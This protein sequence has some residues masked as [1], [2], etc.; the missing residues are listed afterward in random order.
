[1]HSFPP[2]RWLNIVILFVLAFAPLTTAVSAQ[3]GVSQNDAGA[4]NNDASASYND[5]GADFTAGYLLA[6]LQDGITVEQAGLQ[7]M[8]VLSA[9]AL[10]AGQNLPSGLADIYL[11][12]LAPEVEVLTAAGVLGAQPGVMWAEPDYLAHPAAT[13]PNDPEFANQWGLEQVDAPEAWDVE[14]GNANVVIAVVDSGLDLTHPDLASKLWVNPGEIAGN[15]IDDDNNG[16]IDDVNGWNFYAED[17]NIAD[18]NGH[19]TQVAGVAAAVTDNAEGIAGMC[20]GCTIMPIKAMQASGVANYSDIAQGVLYAA[21]KGAEVINLSLGGYSYSSALHE[22][23]QAAVNDY[24]VVVVGGAGNDGVDTPFYPAAYPEVLAVA[25]TDQSDVRA[26]FSDYGT[27]VDV[28]APAVDITTTF[29]GGDYGAVSGTSYAAPLVS[30]LVGLIRSQQ[31]TW[32]QALVTAQIIHTTNDIDP[33]NPG[34]E[35][36]LGS[37][38]I[39]AHAAVTTT[40]SPLLSLEGVAVN[41]DPLGRPTPGESA[42][43]EITLQNDW[44]D[45]EDLTGE[46]STSDPYVTVITD[47]ASYGDILAGGSATGSPAYGFDVTLGAGYSHPIALTLDLSANGGGYSASLDLVVT[48]RSAEEQVWGTI[49]D[50]TTWTNDKTYI[51]MG[52]IGVAP[53]VTLTI[54]AGTDVLFNGNYSLNVGG[55]LVAD[56]MEEQPIRF[57][58]NTGNDWGR[59]YFDDTSIDA[60]A[61]I[62]GTYQSG[63]ILRWV[64]IEGAAQGIGCNNATPYLSHVTTD[65]GGVSCTTGGTSLWLT[66]SDL[67][68][69]VNVMSGSDHLNWS[70]RADLLTARTGLGVVAASNGKIY[71]IG[72]G[73]Y[74]SIVEAYDPQTDTW[75]TQA[76][77]PTARSLLGVA[78]A[79]NGMIYAIGGYNLSKGEL[80]TVE[81]YNPQTDTWTTKASMPTARYGLGVATTSNGKIYAIG[82]Y[83]QDGQILN[84]VEEYDPQADTWVIRANMPTSRGMLGVAAA[85]NDKI[86]AIGGFNGGELNTVEEYDPQIDMWVIR[87]SMPVVRAQLG[88]AAASNGRIYA[89]GGCGNV[90][91]VNTVEEYDPQTNTWVIR[92]SMPTARAELGVTTASNDKIYAIGGTWDGGQLNTVEEFNPLGDMFYVHFLRM[93][94]LNGGVWLIGRSEVLESMVSSSITINGD[95]TIADSAIG[96]AVSL[97]NGSVQNTTITNGGITIGSGEVLSNTLSGGGIS[98]GDGSLVQGNNIEDAFGWCGIQSNGTITAIGNRLV[99]NRAGIEASGGTIAGNLIANTSGVGLKINGDATVSDNTFTGIL[100]NTIIIQSGSPTIQGNNLEGNQGPYDIQNLTANDIPADGNWWGTTDAYAISLRIYDYD[101]DYNLGEVLYTPVATG[102]IQ[103]APAYVRSVTLDPESPVGIETA[104]FDVEF[105]RPMDVEVTP[106]ASFQSLL[107]NTWATY[108][109]DNSGLPG[110][111]VY[112]INS[113]ADGSYWFGTDDGVAHFDGTTWAVYDTGNSELPSNNILAITSNPDGSYW[114]GTEGGVAQF[115]GTT[116]TV[117]TTTNSGLPNNYVNAIAS[118]AD[119]SHWFGTGGGVAHFDGTNWTIYDTSNSGL[120]DNLVFSIANDADGSHWFGTWLGAARFDGTTWT[121]YDSNNSLLPNSNILSMASDADGSLWFGVDGGAAHFDGTTWMTYTTDN[122]WLPNNTIHSIASDADGSHWFGTNGGA[123]KFDG[124]T[125]TV[126]APYNSGLPNYTVRSIASDAN[127]SHWFGT[128]SGVGVLWYFPAHPILDNPLW[129][130]ETH[131]QASYDITA[132]VPRGDYRITVEGAVGTDGIEITPNSDTTFTVDYA[133]AVGDTTP[134]PAPIVLACGADSADTL[135]AHWY[136]SDPD[137]EITLYQY[138]VGTTAG[139]SDVINWTTTSESNFERS[140]LSLVPGQTYY[141]SVKAR[142]AGGLYSEAGVSTGVVAGSGTCPVVEFSADVLSGMAPLTVQFTDQSSGE[143]SGWLWDFGDGSTS[144]EQNPT[145]VYEQPGTYTVTLLVYGPGG[146]GW[147][148]AVDYIVVLGSPINKQVY[149]PMVRK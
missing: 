117:Y 130:D 100:S 51:V 71:A 26:S 145:H 105:S 37:G 112:T 75:E 149:L 66:D 28:S 98:A 97:G 44:L 126:Y 134:P 141:V 106:Q 84:T 147:L 139:S 6:R 29:L 110:N 124:T 25:G 60:T 41:G 19:G 65:R 45:A 76:S 18:D 83:G 62:S 99:G 11:L 36:L 14:T 96:G 87:H 16:L 82:G 133:G 114:F 85:S 129:L 42:T 8:G 111:V 70:T 22:A 47:T 143:V 120:P 32:S 54:Q 136:A 35:G 23:I 27:W 72:G 77:M 56:G 121:V 88:V 118:D 9:T 58:S 81:E 148:E 64:T 61:D 57:L 31:P 20:W 92:P 39:N 128:D 34:Y 4:S 119:G 5:A 137:S 113:G 95:G 24:G 49:G 43:L 127:G 115:D 69:S 91:C 52:N 73:Q 108:N 30:G 135:S 125:W 94:V 103:T 7:S 80:N 78:A 146:S 140:G 102:P 33:L 50:D 144:T 12:Q 15:G 138:A 123:A 40:P 21:Q 86:Y 79:S 131:F 90:E 93:R 55:Q 59:I 46:L 68:G 48:T 142:N 107:N 3:A 89:I 122:S 116:W 109:T 132:L 53:G 2:S 17:A 63:N 104:T 67:V 1:M 38:R 101:D 10:F 13:T 74:L